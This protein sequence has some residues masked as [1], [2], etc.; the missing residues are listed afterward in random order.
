MTVRRRIGSILA[1]TVA[2]GALTTSPAHAQPGVRLLGHQTIAHG[3]EFEGTVVGGLSGIDYRPAT[4][5]Y[6]LISDDRSERGPARFYTARAAVGA[7]G[8]GAVEFT[9]TRP[10]LSANGAP[11]APKSVDPEEIRVDPWSGDFFWTQEGERADGVL[12]DP[13]VRVSRPDGAFAGELPI[14]DNERMRPDSGPRRN[15][16]LEAATF[17]AGGSLFVTALE[18]PLLEDGPDA[19]VAHGALTRI[20]VQG[21]FGPPL[22]QFAY[23]LE[24]VFTESSPEPGQGTN[25]V[26]SILAAD[27]LDPARLLVLERSFVVGAGNKIRIYEA[28]LA[29]A[30]NVL[31]APLAGARP[32]AKRLL[33]DLGEVGLA[34]VDNVEGMTWG[35]RLPSGERTLILVSDDNFAPAQVTQVIALAVR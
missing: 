33:A 32:V 23:P 31:D 16:A 30:T 24:P 12:D 13:A 11:Y 10:L 8:L 9:G 6:V 19:T 25:G 17:A 20:T 28:D 7:H 34:H 15:A 4:G 1:L 14:P 27:P 5:D 22:A 26:A 29:G 35:P 2:I 18:G 3:F 21:R